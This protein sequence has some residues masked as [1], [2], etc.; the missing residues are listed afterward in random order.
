[1]N[2][3]LVFLIPP[4]S[5]PSSRRRSCHLT[6]IWHADINKA[7]T[8]CPP[9][10]LKEP[11][12]LTFRMPTTPQIPEPAHNAIRARSRKTA[13][14]CWY[15]QNP[16]QYHKTFNRMMRERACEEPGALWSC[17]APAC[18]HPQFM[19]IPLDTVISREDLS[20]RV[21]RES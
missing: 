17:R 3:T 20:G 7:R 1:M 19:F 8:A 6:H 16:R 9:Q 15:Q 2:F 21:R 10:P 11:P 14:L 5:A 12:P 18:M 13:S 4:A